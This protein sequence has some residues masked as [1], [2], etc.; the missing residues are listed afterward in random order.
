MNFP[1]LYFPCILFID[2]FFI[3]YFCCIHFFLCVSLRFF[4]F[5]IFL[6]YISLVEQHFHT[7]L[8]SPEQFCTHVL[9]FATEVVPEG[10]S[11]NSPTTCS[12]RCCSQC[13]C[14]LRCGFGSTCVEWRSN[15]RPF[16]GRQTDAKRATSPSE[17]A[18]KMFALSCTSRS[19]RK[20]SSVSVSLASLSFSVFPV[21]RH[22]YS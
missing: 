6:I 10:A 17:M 19:H 18:V 4:F 9:T 8:T 15:R 13:F 14:C 1:Q 2:I 5:S 21:S 16:I 11:L 12:H 22:A 3:S 20:C 7:S